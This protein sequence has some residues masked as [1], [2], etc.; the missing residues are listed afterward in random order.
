MSTKQSNEC[1]CD[2]VKTLPRETTSL[3]ILPS[4]NNSISHIIKLLLLGY[5]KKCSDQQLT[6]IYYNI[7]CP[8]FCLLLTHTT[9]IKGFVAVHEAL[10]NFQNLPFQKFLLSISNA[11]YFKLVVTRKSHNFLG[12]LWRRIQPLIALSLTRDAQSFS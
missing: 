6:S 2:G 7:A 11:K 5:C 10:Q 8:N 4:N 3:S 1:E 9:T 12:G